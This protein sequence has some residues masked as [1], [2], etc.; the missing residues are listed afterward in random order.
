MA[1]NQ[2]CQS[3]AMKATI[4]AVIIVMIIVVPQHGNI[5]LERGEWGN[6]PYRRCDTDG[7]RVSGVQAGGEG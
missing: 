7:N 6:Q 5:V 3:A 1:E 4:N 2:F